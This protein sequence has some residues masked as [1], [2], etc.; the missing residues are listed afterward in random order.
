MDLEATRYALAREITAAQTNS[1]LNTRFVDARRVIT[2]AGIE[3][4]Q[5]QYS[6]GLSLGDVLLHA[7]SAPRTPDRRGFA[8]LVLD[9]LAVDGLIPSTSERPD[10]D[11]NVCV[12]PR[13]DRTRDGYQHRSSSLRA[14]RGWIASPR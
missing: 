3:A 4:L 13:G 10:I 14:H 11:R 7:V 5:I 12:P 9:A 2:P 8:V 1:N 6:N